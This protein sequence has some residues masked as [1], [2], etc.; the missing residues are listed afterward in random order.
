MWER[1]TLK[2]KAKRSFK[3]NYWLVVLVALIL[4]MLSGGGSA[5]GSSYTGNEEATK[6]ESVLD[7]KF[8]ASQISEAKQNAEDNVSAIEE[9]YNKMSEEDKESFGVAMGVAAVAIG[10]I[11]IIIALIS[12][13][14]GV[15]VFNPLLV[16]CRKFFTKNLNEKAK[17]KEVV[18]AFDKNYKNGVKIM[19]LK[20]LYTFLWTLL[21]VIPG[22][23]KTY[24]YRMVPYLVAMNPEI[25]AEEAFARSKEMMNG[26]KWRAFILDLSF[27]GWDI[28]NLCTL[29]ILG[30][31][32][33][34]PYRYQTEAALFEALYVAQN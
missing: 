3:A 30:I 18:S 17:L 9:E 19:F 26:N 4:A 25:S 33:V 31:F 8:G 5:G 20:D 14:F 12:M 28:L 22:V 1:K 32:F 21:F 29:G 13:A 10:I 16:G 23:I 27:I 7:Q 24:E 2:E 15:F 6:I 34:N 11:V